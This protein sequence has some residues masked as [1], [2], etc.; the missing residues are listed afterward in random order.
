MIPPFTGAVDWTAST[1]EADEILEGTLPLAE[2]DLNETSTL[3][4]HQ[5]RLSTA[6]NSISSTVTD[7]DWAVKMKV[8]RETTTTSPSDMH[9]GHRKALLKDFPISDE[10]CPAGDLTL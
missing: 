2:D 3:F 1:P 4:L 5:F 6:L 9:L 8:W 7:G 10:I